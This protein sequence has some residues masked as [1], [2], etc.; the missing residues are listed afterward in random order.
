[1]NLQITTLTCNQCSHRWV[2]RKVRVWACPSCRA[3]EWNEPKIVSCLCSKCGNTVICTH[4][5]KDKHAISL[6]GNCI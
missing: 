2:P 5:P 6:C 1:M 3:R 4:D